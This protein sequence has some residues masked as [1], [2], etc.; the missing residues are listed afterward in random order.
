M[1]KLIVGFSGR[2][3]SGKSYIKDLLVEGLREATNYG[4]LDTAFAA[5]IKRAMISIFGVEMARYV[6]DPDLKEQPIPWLYNVTARS[7]MQKFGT[8]FIRENVSETFWIDTLQRKIDES[9]DRIVVLDDLRFQNEADF[10]RK[11]NG[12]IVRV[13]GPEEGVI[14]APSHAS[15]KLFDLEKK[16]IIFFNNRVPGQAEEFVVD[17]AIGHILKRL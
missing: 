17:L 8:E 6:Y 11:N 2:K 14:G 9:S 15:E 1:S 16:D 12:I 3:G 4:V 7:L 10:I 5:D 13:V